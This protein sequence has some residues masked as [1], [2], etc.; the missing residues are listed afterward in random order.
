MVEA[1]A[2]G[3]RSTRWPSGEDVDLAFK[4]WVNDLDI[5]YD[6][7]VLVDHVGK[8]SASRLDDWKGLWAKNRQHF[9]DKWSGDTEVPRLESC[10]PD[11]F[12]R[13]RAIAAAAA[14]WMAK[15]F[16]A[17]D[18]PPTVRNVLKQ[19]PLRGA[20]RAPA[21]P[22][23]ALRKRADRLQ[24]KAAKQAGRNVRRVKRRTPPKVMR[25]VRIVL[26]WFPPTVEDSLR[27]AV[28]RVS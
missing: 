4:V 17:R 11:R 14:A 16:K 28:R 23:R 27:Q 12:A 21:Q 13:N 18:R 9:L 26:T 22:G 7:R 1:S 2:A 24:R 19:S 6:Q 8:G 5:V 25:S 20:R 10:D 15:Y 3:A